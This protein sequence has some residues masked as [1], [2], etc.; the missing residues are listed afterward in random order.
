MYKT[1]SCKVTQNR[2][3]KLTFD[4]RP[5]RANRHNLGLAVVVEILTF[6]GRDHWDE[7]RAHCVA[8]GG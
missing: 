1:D 3:L 6:G 8:A 4:H 5:H 2:I 7:A